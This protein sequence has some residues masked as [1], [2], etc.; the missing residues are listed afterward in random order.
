MNLVLLGIFTCNI[1][2]LQGAIYL[3][4]GHGIVSAG[5]FFMIGSL[6]Q[7]HG[8]RLLNYYSGLVSKMPIFSSYFFLFCLANIATP[9]TCNFIGELMIFVSL[10]EKNFFSLLI[11][12]TSI[13]LSVIYTMFLFNRIIFGNLKTNYIRN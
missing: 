9:S 12:V 4:L 13:I 6:Y 1:Y 3:M 11:T 7:K 10:I 2:G 5:L 8:T